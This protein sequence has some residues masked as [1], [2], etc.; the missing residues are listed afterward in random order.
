MGFEHILKMALT[1]CRMCSQ[2]VRDDGRFWPTQWNVWTVVPFSVMETPGGGASGG[3]ED[4][5]AAF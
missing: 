5:G 4:S 3:G 2:K 1:G